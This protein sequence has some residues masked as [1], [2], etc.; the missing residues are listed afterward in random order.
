MRE[1][2]VKTE[3]YRCERGNG[4]VVTHIPESDDIDT[5]ITFNRETRRAAQLVTAV[6]ASTEKGVP[7][8]SQECPLKRFATWEQF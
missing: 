8:T 1:R 5:R 4:K 3:R 6:C 7:C 2:I